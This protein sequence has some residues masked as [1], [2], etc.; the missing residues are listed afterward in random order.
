MASHVYPLAK[1]SF[2]SGAIDLTS[3][4]LKVALLDSSYTYSSSHQYINATGFSG[5]TIAT[6]GNLASK[7]VTNG[8]F[9]AANITLTAVATGHTISALAVYRDS[10]SSAT[11]DLI[12]YVDGLSQATNG[13]DITV[14][15]D[16]GS[17]KIFAL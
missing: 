11:S 16:T 4:N 7:T 17:N 8:V 9:N 12:C 15:W 6:S 1:Q 2:I 10:G 14:S 3:V 5:A 13:G